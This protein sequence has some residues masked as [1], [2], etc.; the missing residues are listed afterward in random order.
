L[1][2]DHFHA[3]RLA[4]EAVNDV[5]RRVQQDQLGHRGRRHDPLYGIRRLLLRTQDAHR[6]Y[7]QFGFAPVEG[8]F[9][10]RVIAVEQ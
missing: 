7:E 5:R 1:V 3:I 10:D 8:G 4:S 2:I 6:L 9:M